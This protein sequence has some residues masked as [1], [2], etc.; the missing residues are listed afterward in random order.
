METVTQSKLLKPGYKFQV[1]ITMQ[2]G[3]THAVCANKLKQAGGTALE[4][5]VGTGAIEEHA[6]VFSKS[7]E[8]V[9]MSN[10]ELLGAIRTELAK[11]NEGV[12][13]MKGLVR[14]LEPRSM[15]GDMFDAIAKAYTV[16]G[17]RE[18]AKEDASHGD[19]GVLYD[20]AE[21]PALTT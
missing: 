16:H 13:M 9:P 3:K 2:D 1:V 8:P 18:Y 21:R 10:E 20:K 19:I 12:E 6:R 15:P 7:L 14:L 5:F 17:G 4:Y 11:G